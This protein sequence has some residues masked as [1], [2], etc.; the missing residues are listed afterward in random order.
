MKNFILVSDDGSTYKCAPQLVKQLSQAEISKFA[1][2]ASTGGKVERS[3]I[4]MKPT[5]FAGM[6]HFGAALPNEVPTTSLPVYSVM[7][8]NKKVAFSKVQQLYFT[9]EFVATGADPTKVTLRGY[10][11]NT[12]REV[13]YNSTLPWSTHALAEKIGTRIYF[14]P[15]ATFQSTDYFED[16]GADLSRVDW[17]NPNTPVTGFA[18]LFSH[19]QEPN[20]TAVLNLAMG[21]E[22]KT[23]SYFPLI[24]N[25]F[26]DLKVCLGRYYPQGITITPSTDEEMFIFMLVSFLFSEFNADLLAVAGNG[27]G[28][29]DVL[30]NK[31]IEKIFCWDKNTLRYSPTIT[32]NEI[33][34]FADAHVVRKF[35][36]DIAKRSL[37]AIG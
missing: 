37:D 32:A 4:R 34:A 31:I 16:N 30:K 24:S 17:G 23:D 11:T 9:G 14:I 26:D 19:R 22:G 2:N 36:L 6:T 12:N 28:G 20:Q 8:N 3:S 21:I 33:L 18:N 13:L 10:S 27:G 29:G 35:A 1:S 15:F 7:E 5:R 25:V